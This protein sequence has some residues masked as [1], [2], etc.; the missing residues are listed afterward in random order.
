MQSPIRPGIQAGLEWNDLDSLYRLK[1]WEQY[2]FSF[3]NFPLD[4]ASTLIIVGTSC[5]QGC[6]LGLLLP[7]AVV[8]ALG[9]VFGFLPTWLALTFIFFA[10]YVLLGNLL[11]RVAV[12]LFIGLSR[13][14]QAA[15]ILRP[16]L[17]VLALPVQLASH[18][19][20]ASISAPDYESRFKKMFQLAAIETYPRTHVWHRHRVSEMIADEVI[21]PWML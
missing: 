4:I 2:L 14:A 20:I 5:L 15:P 1:T 16:L 3:F 11:G 13:L 6:L 8:G 10:A 9:L 12:S 17:F 21:F 18:F 19:V 7:L